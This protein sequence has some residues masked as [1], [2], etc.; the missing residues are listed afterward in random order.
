MQRCPVGRKGRHTLIAA[1][2]EAGEAPRVLAAVCCDCGAVRLLELAMA[3]DP[4]PLDGL[5]T[6]EITR[7]IG[8]R[9]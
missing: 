3:V 1:T 8:A 9:P 7:R 6:D 4:D 5:S 2:G